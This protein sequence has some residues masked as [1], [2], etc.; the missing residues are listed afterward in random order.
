[1]QE[2]AQLSVLLEAGGDLLGAV[3]R[4][5]RRIAAGFDWTL[6]YGGPAEGCTDETACNYNPAAEVD[7]G[8]CIYPGDPL[9]TGPDLMVVESAIENSLQAETMMVDENNCYIVE[10]CLNGYGERE[11]VRFTTHIKN[12]GDIDYYIGTNRPV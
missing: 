11:L 9:C 3:C 5:G 10:G 4:S 1:M 6:A 2:S 7:N 12:I 8:G